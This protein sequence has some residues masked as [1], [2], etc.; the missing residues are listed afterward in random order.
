[1]FGPVFPALASASATTSA[2]TS[3]STFA[4][5]APNVVAGLGWAQPSCYAALALVRDQVLVALVRDQPEVGLGW[6]QPACYAALALGMRDQVLVALG[7][8]DQL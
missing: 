2:S 6:A 4:T 5:P 8:R 3:A 7:M 1:M